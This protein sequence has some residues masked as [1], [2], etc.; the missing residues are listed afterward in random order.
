MIQS[1]REQPYMT[2]GLR[3]GAALGVVGLVPP[4][5]TFAGVPLDTINVTT[6]ITVALAL[7]AFLLAGLVTM[8]ATGE[9]RAG[10]LAGL[11]AGVIF[12]ALGGLGNIALALFD[13][14]AYGALLFA[15][16]PAVGPGQLVLLSVIRTLTVVLLYAGLGAAVGG[17]GALLARAR[18]R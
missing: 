6:N 12:A 10:A 9:V 16:Q 1:V 18:A 3:V 5:L 13:G 11:V 8:R 4:V 2:W 7:A 15:G 14:R 17:L